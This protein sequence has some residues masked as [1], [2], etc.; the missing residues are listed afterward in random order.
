MSYTAFSYFWL[1]LAFILAL[2]AILG[3][4]ESY[5]RHRRE[6]RMRRYQPYATYQPYGT[7]H[8]YDHYQPYDHYQNW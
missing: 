7:Y 6:A 5:L 4:V 1:L 2:T 8:Q 3:A